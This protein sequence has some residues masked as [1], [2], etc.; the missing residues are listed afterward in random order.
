MFSYQF[1]WQTELWININDDNGENI[2]ILL[3]II[4]SANLQESKYKLLALSGKG[5]QNNA[6]GS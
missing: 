5:K 6:T 3:A 1:N 2:S 4:I